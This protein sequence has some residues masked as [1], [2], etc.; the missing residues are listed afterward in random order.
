MKQTLLLLAVIIVA[1]IIY[2]PILKKA[3]VDIAARTKAGLSNGGVYAVLLI[4]LVGPF[5]YLLFRRY[6][7][8]E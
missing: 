3:R 1:A 6:F 8:V 7:A 2:W 5:V 4:P